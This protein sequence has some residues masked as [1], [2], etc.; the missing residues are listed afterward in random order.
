MAVLQNK[1]Y[2]VKCDVCEK[3]FE[4][5]KGISLFLSRDTAMEEAQD[6]YWLI[7]KHKCY[8]PECYEVTYDDGYI[9][10]NK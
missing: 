10:K 8:C 6:D 1:T 4:N 9:I 3:T 5:F 2:S 7:D